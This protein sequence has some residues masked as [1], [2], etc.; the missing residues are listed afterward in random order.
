MNNKEDNPINADKTKLYKNLLRY[1]DIEEKVSEFLPGLQVALK[2]VLAVAI[3][4]CFRFPA[5]V[6]L[7]LVDVP[8]SGKTDLV[9][10]IKDS[11]ITYYLDNLTQNAFVSGERVTKTNKVHDLLPLLDNKC[12]V[13]KDWTSIFSLDEKATKKILGDLVNIYDK[14]FAKF[15]SSRGLIPYESY[16]SH[17]G[18]ITP[19]TLNK[20]TQYLNMIGARFLFYNLPETS[21]EN[22]KASREY[23]FSGKDR[24]ELEAEAKKYV[25]SYLEQLTQLKW[26]EPTISKEAENY[27]WI[28]A[29]LIAHC[30]GIVILQPSKFMNEE[31]KERTSYQVIAS[32]IEKPWRALYQL[33]IL[34]ECLAFVVWKDFVEIDELELIKEIVLASMPADR[35]QVLKI[36]QKNNGI[37]TAKKLSEDSEIAYKTSQRLLEELVALKVLNK[38]KGSGSM[39]ADYI[40]DSQYKDYICLPTAEF[41]SSYSRETETPHSIHSD[42]EL[43]NEEQENKKKVRPSLWD[44]YLISKPFEELDNESLLAY[45]DFSKQYSTGDS[46]PLEDRNKFK[47]QAKKLEEECKKRNLIDTGYQDINIDN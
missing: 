6:W 26:E 36:I 46:I 24:T 44:Q 17:L 11:S 5:M 9:R 22:E 3:A 45:L 8:S 13:V 27:I 34:A 37:I 19:A 25:S 7:L 2:V 39:P 28:G 14:E 20:H 15:S 35:S 41:M 23:I 32:Q 4:S 18:C 31:G 33:K 43:I 42:D 16:F 10:L 40:L 21:E 47:E 30:R 12:F 38:I 1:E 29:N